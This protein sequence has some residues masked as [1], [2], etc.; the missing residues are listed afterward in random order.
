MKAPAGKRMLSRVAWM[1]AYH[2]ELGRCVLLGTGQ[3][4][5]GVIGSIPEATLGKKC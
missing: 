3:T 2:P 5:T 1:E 4:M